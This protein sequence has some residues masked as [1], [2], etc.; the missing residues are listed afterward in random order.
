MESNCD[1]RKDHDKY[2]ELRLQVLLK[3]ADFLRAEALFCIGRVR[4]VALFSIAIAGAALPAMATVI[5]SGDHGNLGML[6][7]VRLKA[8]PLQVISLGVSLSGACLLQIYIGVFKQIFS[9]SAY[10]R[11]AL[12]PDI[13]RTLAA[14]I[15]GKVHSPV[16]QWEN[17]LQR[18]RLESVYYAAHIELNAEPALIALV[19]LGYAVIFALVSY[20]SETWM[21]QSYVWVIFM[22]CF[23]IDKYL[24]F[25]KVSRHSM[26]S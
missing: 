17:W 3:D 25:R 21:I 14:L 13:N 24:S 1:D 2:L 15:P 7:I 22:L 5:G 18:K 19:S 23:L 6:E 8:L 26:E 16:F 12:I 10:F 11:A 9:F 4:Y 20:F